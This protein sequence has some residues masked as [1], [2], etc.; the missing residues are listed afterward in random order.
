MAAM[1][2]MSISE[3]A[4]LV[5]DDALLGAAFEREYAG[6]G[7]AHRALDVVTGRD[8]VLSAREYSEL[9]RLAFGRPDPANL[10]AHVAALRELDTM[11]AE[12]EAV[13]AEVRRVLS[14]VLESPM[15]DSA[16]EI[17]PRS[18][19][20]FVLLAIA[21]LVIVGV[22][23]AALQIPA[24]SL[25][26]FDRP[27]TAEEARLAEE[28]L[29]MLGTGEADLSSLRLLGEDEGVTFLA[30]KV[31]HASMLSAEPGICFL[32]RTHD[33]GGSACGVQEDVRTT[34][35]SGTSSGPSGRYTY[36]WGPTGPLVFT[37]SE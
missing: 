21:L 36:S 18:A 1:Q 2:E 24:P 8:S 32:I 9:A 30:A 11:S 35:L 22:V 25:A 4:E 14:L 29:P 31:A 6:P 15:V 37:R 33:G 12:R 27:Q 16:P 3:V 7:D 19:N 10:E 26:V 5:R 23:S 17:A 13:T 34:G 20:A 28:M